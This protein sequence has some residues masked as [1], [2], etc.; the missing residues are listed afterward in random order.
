VNGLRIPG[1]CFSEGLSS[2]GTAKV[3]T[4]TAGQQGGKSAT[5]GL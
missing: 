1:H 4:G 3:P 2:G 5:G